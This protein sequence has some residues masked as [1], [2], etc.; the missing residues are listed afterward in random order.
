MFVIFLTFNYYSP[1]PKESEKS[2]GDDIKTENIDVD[3]D[4][5]AELVES[6]LELDMEGCVEPDTDVTLQMGDNS[7]EPT[8]EDLDQ[9]SEMRSKGAA[10]Y[11]EQKYDEAI[12]FYTEAIK[13]NPSNALFYAKR[14]QVKLFMIL[15]LFFHFFF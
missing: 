13:L 7:K 2:H 11:S 9:A 3:D 5:D 10:A 1:K 4:D 15:L 14:G 12:G 8:E 6:D